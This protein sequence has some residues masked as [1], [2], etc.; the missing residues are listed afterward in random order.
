MENNLF[1]FKGKSKKLGKWLY[2]YLGESRIKILN[3]EY[4]EK[5]IFDNIRCFNSDNISFIIDDLAVEE[6]TISRFTGFNDKNNKEIWE[7]D[8]V[9]A[10]ELDPIFGAIIKDSFCNA[11]IKFNDGS[12]VVSYNNG[13]KNIYLSD[14]YD[15]IEVIGNKFDNSE[16]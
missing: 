9:K 14:L 8:I 1:K 6:N 12:F 16:I 11:I 13:E 4:I 2:G 10:P 5:V 7:N 15:M 3:T